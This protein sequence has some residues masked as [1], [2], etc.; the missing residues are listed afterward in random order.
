MAAALVL[1]AVVGCGQPSVPGEQ[2]QATSTSTLAS[3][4]HDLAKTRV[5]GFRD[6]DWCRFIV[7]A[8]GAFT[9][10]PDSEGGC[11]AFRGQP[12]AFDAG[13]TADWAALQGEFQTKGV[14]V[15]LAQIDYDASGQI[16]HA[17]FGITPG[18]TTDFSYV[19]DPAH[20][21]GWKDRK[22]LLLHQIDADW[23]FLSEAW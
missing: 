2:Q 6:Q 7:Y 13:A 22:I 8:R 19:Y 23:W 17:E 21:D 20:T 11:N 4:L 12:L 1:A 10:L 15:W 9:N 3:L 14:P 5:E 18:S 16:T